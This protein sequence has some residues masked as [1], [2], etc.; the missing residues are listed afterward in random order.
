MQR[1]RDRATRLDRLR[2]SRVVALVS[3]FTLLASCFP[4]AAF[5]QAT[6]APPP[7]SPA[8][9]NIQ[10]GMTDLGVAETAP[11]AESGALARANV[12]PATGTLH[13]SIPFE[14]PH[15]R[16]GI[17]PTLSLDYSSAGGY[18]VG[19]HGWSLSLPA[20]ERHNRSGLP[21]YKSVPD[22]GTDV[23]PT[24][25]TTVDQFTFG[26]DNLLPVASTPSPSET[27]PT[28]ATRG[29]IYYRLET[30]RG[31]N[32]RFFLSPDGL[33]WVVQEPSGSTMELGV[34]RD[35]PVDLWA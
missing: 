1:P 15:A 7:P 35:N 28:W 8:P 23:D 27:W 19:G 4:S 3:L 25:W 33:T 10:E 11:S 31:S 14:L 29:W 34:P 12:D 9:A 30:E 21:L 6:G 5:A 18:G 2:R 16:G 20:I 17:Q 24:D 13:A 22:A 26:G 32:L